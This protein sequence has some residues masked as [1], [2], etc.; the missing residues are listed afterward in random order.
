M[1]RDELCARA[2]QFLTGRWAE[3]LDAATSSVPPRLAQD[4]SI[5][6]E[7]RRG[8]AAQSRIQ[9]GQISWTR[10]ELTGAALAPRDEATFAELQGR[11]P[12]EQARPIPLQVL[13]FVL[14]RA[15]ELNQQEFVRCSNV[16]FWECPRSGWVRERN[17]V[18]VFGRP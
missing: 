10:H 9:R 6:E 1:G 11:R 15:L 12:Q 14:V 17:V 3:L 2:D 13:E 18:R 7:E 16:P 8:K 5:S 4:I